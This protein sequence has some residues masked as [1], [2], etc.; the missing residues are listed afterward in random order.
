[1]SATAAVITEKRESNPAYYDKLSKRIAEII[2]EYKEKRLTEEEKLKH[3]KEIRDMLLKEDVKEAQ[4]YPEGIKSNPQARAF[5]DNLQESFSKALSNTE[6]RILMTEEKS[7]SFDVDLLTQTVLEITEIF[8]KASKK[9]DW[10]NNSDMRNKIEGQIE[11]IFWDIEDT[12]G[13]KFD[14]S[15]EL[16]ATIQQIGVNNY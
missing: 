9:P 16:L 4:N 15:D 3:A 1:M 2:E 11:D 8:E 14:N 13:I 5:Y 10:K 6:E 12:Y 7:D